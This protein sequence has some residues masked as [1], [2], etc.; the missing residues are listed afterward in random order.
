MIKYSHWKGDYMK[1]ISSEK[2]E[3]LIAAKRRKEKEEDIAKWLDISKGSVGTIWRLFRKTG[4][5][6]PTAYTGRPSAIPQEKVDEIQATVRNNPDITLSELIE[7]LSL[8]IQNLSFRGC[9]FRWVILSKKDNL[10]GGARPSRRSRKAGKVPREDKIHKSRKSRPAWRKFSQPRLHTALWTRNDKWTYQRRCGWRTFRAQIHFINNTVKWN[11]VSTGFRR[12][13]EQ[14]HL[15]PLH[16]IMPKTNTLAGKY[17]ALR[18]LIRTYIEAGF[19]YVERVRHYLSV[20]AAVFTGPQSYRI[21]VGTNEV[22]SQ[23]TQS[24]NS[25]QTGRCY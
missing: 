7:R 25:R 15:C 5:F 2:R 17:S 13:F 22:G 24:T 18:Q 23:E 11:D 4:S 20:P 12:N 16:K 10:S 21:I 14:I 6:L 8:P 19:G 3:L 9:W 1:P